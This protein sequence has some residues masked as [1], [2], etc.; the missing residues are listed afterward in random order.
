MKVQQVV[1]LSSETNVSIH[2]DVLVTVRGSI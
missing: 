2:L 1:F